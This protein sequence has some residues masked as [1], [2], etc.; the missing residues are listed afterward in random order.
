MM[1]LFRL[2][3]AFGTLIVLTGAAPAG[4]Q[5]PERVP[6]FV[7]A[8]N[9]YMPDG[10]AASIYLPQHDTLYLLADQPNAV[11][12]RNTLIYFWPID[13]EYRADW[14]ARNDLVSSVLEISGNNR[15]PQTFDLTNYVVQYDTAEPYDSLRITT[16]AE[17]QQRYDA[18][19][20]ERNNYWKSVQ[21]YQDRF[22]EYGAKL[23]E[24]VKN[25]EGGTKPQPVPPAPQ[26]P[27]PF[28]RQSSVPVKSFVFSLPAGEY[29]MRLRD[30]GGAW[31][32]GLDRKLVVFRERRQAISYNVVPQSK[33][34]K[35]EQSDDPGQAIY[36]PGQATLYFAPF[37]AAEYNDLYY[38]RLANPQSTEGRVDQWQWIRLKALE[39]TTLHVRGQDGA[40]RAV[41][42]AGYRVNQLPGAALGY[43]VVD[44]NPKT[45][46]GSPSFTGFKLV[47]DASQPTFSIEL[48]DSD[49]RV[50]PGSQREV[51]ALQPVNTVLWFALP[52]V[53]LLAGAAI[54]LRR[55]RGFAKLPPDAQG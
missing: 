40:T 49:G 9:A 15:P 7:Y 44:Y 31:L 6:A 4:A 42:F 55:R 24:A 47:L 21:D 17:A 23:D 16:G 8:V 45:M 1:R 50:M 29:R 34:T 13:N 5:A 35:P 46:R 33:W 38:A 32:P 30:P 39:G 36:A 3:L 20:D 26:E 11:A 19:V 22:A 48:K 54:M 12:P 10:Y 53:P 18:F 25:S 14:T 37:L 28:T 27:P 2:W 52:A 51:R 41:L 43:E